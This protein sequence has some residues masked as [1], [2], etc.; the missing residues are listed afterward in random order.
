[1]NR[2]HI[3]LSSLVVISCLDASGVEFNRDIRPILSE[4]CFSC[5][6]LDQQK[7]GLR[8][9][10]ETGAL[11]GGKSGKA[12]IT[13]GKPN[14]SEL[15]A[16]VTHPG[17]DRMPPK[18]NAVQP[19]NVKQIA[20]LQQWITEGGKYQKHWAYQ[21]PIKPVPPDVN[22]DTGNPID[23]FIVAELEKL[24]LQLSPTAEKARLLR[25]VHLDLTGL[26]PTLKQ[27]DAFLEEDSPDAYTMVVDRLLKSKRYGE[28]WARQWLDLARYADSNGFQ[29]D[30]L[31][32]SWAYRDWV[33][34][35]MNAD[36]PFD[37]FTVEQIAGDL[38]PSPTLAQKIA[39]GF[40]RTPTC[41]VE[42]GVDPE[43]NRT[44]QVVDRVNTTGTVWLGTTL[45]C[46]Q[47]HSHK[48]DPFSQEDYYR[49]FSFFNNT[50]LEV[51]GKGGVS[52]NFYGPKLDLPL[53]GEQSEKMAQVV[54]RLSDAETALALAK[55][56]AN[57]GF[58][59]WLSERRKELTLDVKKVP[60]WKVLDFT[61]WKSSGKEPFELLKDG[62]LLAM[63]ISAD[64]T[65]YT[66]EAKAPSTRIASI[67]LDALTH[68]SLKKSGPG[69]NTTNKNPNFVL[70][71]LSVFLRGPD[72]KEIPIALNGAQASFS[73]G[74]FSVAH[75]ID[76]KHEP[77]NGW[78][79]APEFGKPHWA[80]FN[81]TT[82]VT[83][84]PGSSLVFKLNHVYGGGRNVGRTLLSVSPTVTAGG[85][86]SSIPK[87]IIAL[88]KKNKPTKK[89]M[90]KLREQCMKE[91]PKV[92]SLEKDVDNAKKAGDGIKKY[93]T[94]VMVEME[95]ARKTNVMIRGQFM[96][97]GKA[98]SPG[99]PDSLHA[100]DENF[101]GNRLGFAKWLV[102]K[103]NPLMARV[104][105]NRWWGQ[106]MG[107]GIVS[108]EEDFG[109]QS[110]PPTHPKLLDWLAIEFMENKW[111]MKHIHRTIVL[112]DTYRQSSRITPE[113]LKQD[114]LNRMYA[115]GPRF[116]MTAE[117]IRDNALQVSGI[118]SDKMHGPPI[119]PPQPD[120]LWKQVG[121]NEPKYAAATDED[122]FRR[123]IYIIWRRAAPYPSF[124]NFDGP[125]RSACH[126]RRSRTNTPLQALT[127]LND[128]AYIEM[129]LAF[130]DSILSGN[131]TLSLEKKIRLAFRRTVARAPT[132]QE[133]A[134]LHELYKSEIID[135]KSN[136]LRATELIG[137]IKGYKASP[138]LDPQELAAW[139]AIANTLL[140]LD[141]TVTKS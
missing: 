83:P 55:K 40:H 56:K 124:V 133:I 24:S 104:T 72:G 118:L 130:A 74:S 82:P 16:R 39:T 109:S 9:D 135:L 48:Y 110:E 51:E 37:Q 91:H 30:Q 34:D 117:M 126:P 65:L 112:S 15:L 134:A 94:L 44:N 45:E 36:M 141:E 29:A 7:G 13:P 80:T 96:E 86:S 61:N 67:K 8:L 10:L 107:R 26:P 20:V 85:K 76:G 3:V 119:Y 33:I 38:L 87:D 115:R 106:F 100:W 42:A 70:S 129:A 19:L 35:A 81:L 78:A 32:D 63:G 122:R 92:K 25:R 127:L 114:P 113:L 4:K 88:L 108:T 68:K 27:L 128:E 123:G 103:E 79:I 49:I 12:A 23:Q 31:R 136:P 41:N 93:S 77:R 125:D 73:Q 54:A 28:H 11:K 140:N 71:E 50:P 2:L 59:Q 102:S 21:K 18:K 75:L 99:T 62:S 105:V 111:S 5:H 6:G 139:F 1:M 46:A 98:V 47:C 52:Y 58:N 89:E 131:P 90:E 116:R 121:R 138:G 64:K 17:D 14:D 101:S 132:Q 66:F 43:E 53:S 57:A 137:S 95:T 69:R 120:G 84:E 60:D 22:A 97:K